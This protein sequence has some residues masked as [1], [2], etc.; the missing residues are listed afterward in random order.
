MSGPVEQKGLFSPGMKRLAV[1]LIL[2][3]L[4][5]PRSGKA[6]SSGE[7][8]LPIVQST[9]GTNY[10]IDANTLYYRPG[11]TALA[12]FKLIEDG[13]SEDSE[14]IRNLAVFGKSFRNYRYTKVLCE[15]GCST[16]KLRTLTISAYD[17][18]GE[19]IHRDETLTGQWTTI[20]SGSC[21]DTIRQILCKR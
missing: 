3:L 21:F 15:I 5:A 17:K 2:A 1:L 12:W 4:L 9:T 16:G 19:V 13:D 14:R 7:K 20:P 8:W 10:Y 18:A 6:D 11:N